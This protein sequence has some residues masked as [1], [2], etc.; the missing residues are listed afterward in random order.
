MR[1]YL[2]SFRMGRCPERLRDL[3][4][5]GRRAVVIANAIDVYPSSDRAAGVRREL[6]AL[7]ALGFDATELDLRDYFDGQPI[8]DELRGHDLVWVRGGDVFT[9]RHSLS[10]SGADVALVRLLEID[11]IAYGGYSAGISVLAPTLRGLEAVDDPAW[12]R[13][14]YGVEPIWDGL[15]LL[16]YCIVPHVSSPDHPESAACDRVAASYRASRTAHRTLRD[17]DVLVIDG[18]TE[19]LCSMDE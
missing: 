6:D 2:S 13:T 9:L 8:V 12:L 1:L 16:D 4:R 7:E 19:H 14:L 11:G 3:V 17:G 15:S 10:K 5:D 18:H